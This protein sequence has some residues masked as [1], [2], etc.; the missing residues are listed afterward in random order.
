EGAIAAVHE[1]LLNARKEGAAILLISEEL[2]EATALS[3][4]IQAILKGRLS[5]PITAEEASA[6]RLGMMMAGMWGEADAA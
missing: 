2:E 1:H 5:T 3:D 4:R 6:E